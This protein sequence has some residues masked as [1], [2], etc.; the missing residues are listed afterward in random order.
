MDLSCGVSEFSNCPSGPLTGTPTAPFSYD[1]NMTNI[2][3]YCS[4]DTF[5]HYNIEY[6]PGTIEDTTGYWTY[7]PNIAEVGDTL[8][9]WID[10]NYLSGRDYCFV[11]LIVKSS[12]GDINNDANI[13]ILDISYLISYLY[14]GGQAPQYP[15]YADVDNTGNM[16]ILDV[17]YLV[18][19]LYKGGPL[20]NCPSAK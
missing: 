1:F 3:T 19:Y 14:R 15:Q 6:G 11:S 2:I 20:P 5:P 4:F 17:S 16:N 13:N 7:L 8:G 18:G 12:C 9:L 10:G